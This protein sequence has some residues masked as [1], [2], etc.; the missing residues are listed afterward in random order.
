MGKVFE[1]LFLTYF[2]NQS[3]L[4][5]QKYLTVHAFS[6]RAEIQRRVGKINV[7]RR[8]G[9]MGMKRKKRRRRKGGRKEGHCFT[10][11]TII[12]IVNNSYQLWCA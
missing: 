6:P 3:A 10:Q 2:L 12:K 5:L 7:K 1:L 11:K 9:R 4:K 8:R